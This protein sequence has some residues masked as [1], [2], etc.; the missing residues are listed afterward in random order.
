LNGPAGARADKQR[1]AGNQ[2]I[3]ESALR[4]NHDANAR[5]LGLAARDSD[6]IGRSRWGFYCCC[7]WLPVVGA[8]GPGGPGPDEL[9]AKLQDP[10]PT[11]SRRGLRTTRSE[12]A[13]RALQVPAPRARAAGLDDSKLLSVT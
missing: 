10:G 6:M 7:R 11:P 3:A 1:L 5:N 8:G 2:Q 9:V 13:G 12:P 4:L